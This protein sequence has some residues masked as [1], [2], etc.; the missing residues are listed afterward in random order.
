M[1]QAEAQYGAVLKAEGATQEVFLQV[2][3]SSLTVW[4]PEGDL[5]E[6]LSYETFDF[7]KQYGEASFI[8]RVEGEGATYVFSGIFSDFMEQLS[9]A[10]EVLE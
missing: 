2:G 1:P 7:Y 5:L 4:G 6:E 3:Q 9:Q 10:T 8:L